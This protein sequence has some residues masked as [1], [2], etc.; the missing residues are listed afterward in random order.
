MNITVETMGHSELSR[1]GNIKAHFI[2][3]IQLKTRGVVLLFLITI[4]RNH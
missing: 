3:G 1:Y 4:V 2:F